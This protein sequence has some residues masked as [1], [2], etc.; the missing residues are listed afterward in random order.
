M[1]V[2]CPKD[3]TERDGRCIFHSEIEGKDPARFEQALDGVGRTGEAR[4]TGWVIPISCDFREA[5]FTQ[6]TDF[7][8]ATFT[9]DASFSGATFIRDANFT[10]AIFAKDAD[11][12]R[13]TFTH[14]A[15]FSAAQ[16]TQDAGFRGAN[17]TQDAE[18]SEATF[19]QH[20]DFS[21]ATFARRVGFSEATFTRWAEFGAAA[22]TQ[23][24]DFSGAT[25]TRGADF[26][27]ATFTHD[28]EFI[29]ATF[30]QDAAF[31]G[32]SFAQD[33]YFVGVFKRS[34]QFDRAIFKG[35]ATLQDC[36]LAE[37]SRFDDADVARVTFRRCRLAGAGFAHAFNLNDAT[38][39]Q[40]D[41]GRW[42]PPHER[43]PGWL[44]RILGPE[45]VAAVV[46]EE[47]QA[48]DVMA[49]RIT[50]E[51]TQQALFQEAETVY[52]E[53]RRS[54]ETH[55]HF[56]EADRFA[57]RELEMRRLGN[58]SGPKTDWIDW[59]WGELRA[60]LFSIPAAY[61]LFGGYG[62]SIRR[63]ALWLVFV[64]FALGPWLLNWID[65]AAFPSGWTG[66]TD[67]VVRTMRTVALLP[68][69]PIPPGGQAH[70]RLLGAFAKQ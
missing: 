18:F 5:T 16:F 15:D 44:N 34:A 14:G 3:A 67:G 11:F 57:T 60:N 42:A 47:T 58:L 61:Q 63:P 26:S 66:Y 7:R 54:L 2:D 31:S 4:W 38:F 17:F 37:P 64:L 23:D 62:Q 33:C 39:D 28:A 65:T 13:A 12:R 19:A 8:G 27:A 59:L 10:G 53:V 29:G 32:A 21:E 24:A 41:W 43:T 46:W 45:S 69:L 25:F 1:G 49:G 50:A 40:C 6:D 30:T 22:F 52:R 51:R 55:K 70:R 68:D 20:A 35:R 48:R 9:Q 36:Q 56:R